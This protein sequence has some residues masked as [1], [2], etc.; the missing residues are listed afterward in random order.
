ML[1]TAGHRQGVLLTIGL[2]HHARGEEKK[3]YAENEEGIDL[4]LIPIVFST[5]RMILFR[6]LK[7]CAVRDAGIRYQ[8]ASLA[9]CAIVHR[10]PY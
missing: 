1:W 6:V 4:N 2:D 3:V 10:H 9:W 8:R 5:L 7:A